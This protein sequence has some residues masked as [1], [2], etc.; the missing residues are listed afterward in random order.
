MIKR[1]LK[2]KHW[3]IFILTIILPFVLQT[4]L[5]VVAF[6]GNNPSDVN[7]YLP[8]LTIVLIFGVFGWFW[9]IGVGLQ[10]HI[11]SQ[12]RINTDKFKLFFIIPL[13][14][15]IVVSL[16]IGDN[17]ET[18]FTSGN[19]AIIIPFH[20]FS[21]FCIFHSIYFVAKTLKTVELQ[22]AVTFS[23]FAGDFFLIWFFP[24]GIWIIQPK[25]NKFVENNDIQIG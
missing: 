16:P 22:R 8:I 13:I 20:L 21:M 2:A 24:I 10:S 15:L 23:D 1:F 7:K 14:Y 25:I 19:A 12:I 18:I 4:I 6:T 5:A 3:E 9:S 11:S 17:H